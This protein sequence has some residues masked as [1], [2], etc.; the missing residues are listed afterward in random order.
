MSRDPVVRVTRRFRAAPERV[1]NA[2]LDPD[3]AGRFMFRTE[4]GELVRCEVDGRVGGRFTIVERR[5]EQDAEHLGEFVRI[6]PPRKLVFMFGTAG[7]D[8]EFSQVDIDISPAP[9]GCELTLTHRMSPQWADWVGRVEEGWGHI[10]GN[11]EKA[12]G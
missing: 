5:G 6:D 12:L 9:D 2:F 1:F 4:G 11:L 7:W 10:L 8:G 3:I